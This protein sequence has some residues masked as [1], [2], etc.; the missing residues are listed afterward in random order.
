VFFHRGPAVGLSGTGSHAIFEFI[1]FVPLGFV[2]KMKIRLVR[3][4]HKSASQNNSGDL[5]L[6]VSQNHDKSH[7]YNSERE[8]KW[9][10]LDVKLVT[11]ISL[12]LGPHGNAR[13]KYLPKF[14]LVEPNNY[15]RSKSNLSISYFQFSIW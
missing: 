6:S 8:R 12:L 4:L 14:V 15:T 5:R 9:A 11:H 10:S 7:V 3:M 1:I 13:A 2:Q